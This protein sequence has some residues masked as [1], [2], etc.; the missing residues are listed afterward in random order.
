MSDPLR[1]LGPLAA[2]LL[3]T[4]VGVFGFWALFKLLGL[5]F[6]GV[7]GLFRAIGRLFEHVFTCLKGIVVESFRYVGS[8]LTAIIFLPMVLG[9][10][11]LGR[12]SA[13]THYGR[14]AGSEI[15]DGALSLYRAAIGYPVR[16][17]GL[18]FLVEGF[19]QRIP[20]VIARAPGSDM[21]VGGRS[22]FDGY[23]V[24][25]SLPPGGSG[26]KLFLA[27][28]SDDKVA[29]LAKAGLHLPDRVVIKSFSLEGGSS[30]PQIVRE[31]R[32]LEAA[33]DLG[34]VYEHELTPTS[35]HYVMPF[36]P[37]DDLGEVGRG[38]HARSGTEGLDAA[39]MRAA[40]GYSSGLLGILAR[41][42]RAGLWHKDI[43][44][45]NIIVSGDRVELVDLGLVTPLASAMTLTTHG[46]EYYRDPELVRQAMQ[47][48]R[49][50]DVDGVKFDLYSAGAVLY[51]LIENEFP[52]HGSLSKITRRCPDALRWIIRRSMADLRSRYGSADEMLEDLRVLLAANDPY[53]VK[54][55]QLPSMGG[56]RVV[57]PDAPAADD[58]FERFPKAKLAGDS[59]ADKPASKASRRPAGPPPHRRRRR[60]STSNK[61]AIA[62]SSAMLAIPALFIGGALVDGVQTV[63]R[64]RA[65]ITQTRSASAARATA[66]YDDKRFNAEERQFLRFIER[67]FQRD[68]NPYWPTTPPAPQPLREYRTAALIADA[69]QPPA[70]VQ[71]VFLGEGAPYGESWIDD[72]EHWVA[73]FEHWLDTQEHALE[74][75]GERRLERTVQELESWIDDLDDWLADVDDVLEEQGWYGAPTPQPAPA[76]PALVADGRTPRVLILATGAGAVSKSDRQQLES[77]LAERLPWVFVS[78]VLSMPEEHVRGDEYQLLSQG[79]VT[80]GTSAVDESGTNERLRARLLDG[81]DLDAILRYEWRDDQDLRFHVIEPGHG[82]RL[83]AR[84]LANQVVQASEAGCA[85]R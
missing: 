42:H 50:Q 55:A 23:E 62:V 77:E 9:N 46:T 19:E 30:L 56:S 14:A 83:L 16:L 3:A 31:S 4:V 21:P 35:F 44:P 72:A 27:N 25:G 52:A 79:L 82:G 80:A 54:P 81:D 33:R 71:A 18:G 84:Q 68:A 28:P 66:F 57:I 48:V 8:A 75:A 61:V 40:L 20:E 1:I 5:L 6:T 76:R 12:W 60:T 26:A 29:Q 85:T 41:F 78:D 69:P 74:F 24:V 53:A 43:K 39:S 17:V 58:V 10:I 13:A 45:N 7:G 15:R 64:E 11:A 47:G 59:V 73:R 65:V 37:G 36:V 51:N 38:L 49:V 63:G 32:A 70:H 22:T 67:G 2:M 34:L